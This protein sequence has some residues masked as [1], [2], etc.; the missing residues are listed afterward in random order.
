MHFLRQ[1][2]VATQIEIRENNGDNAFLFEEIVQ[3][4]KLWK[5]SEEKGSE[6]ESEFEED[7]KRLY[8]LEDK[9]SDANDSTILLTEENVDELM[10]LIEEGLINFNFSDIKQCQNTS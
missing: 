7:F 4:I 1:E 5:L 9:I 10:G 2:V 8:E 3:L 6:V